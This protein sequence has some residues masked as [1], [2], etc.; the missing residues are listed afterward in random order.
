M[1]HELR[2]WPAL[3]SMIIG[4]FML[5]VDGTIVSIATPRIQEEL[6]ADI[7]Q[8]LWV[9][10]AYLLAYAVPLLVTG[11]LGDRL[12][13]KR[14]YLAGLA[15]FTLSSLWC[16]LSGSIEMLI[17]ARVVQGLGAAL[18][19]PQTMSVITRMFPPERRGPAMS[20]WGATA[21]VANL[22]GPILGGSLVDGL[23]WEWIFFVNVPVG[24][25]G[26]VL[27]VRLVPRF[28]PQ[29]HRFDLPGVLLSAL[30]MFLV[31]FGIQEGSTYDWGTISG[32]V[33]VPLLI[34][35]GVVVLAVFVLW[36]ARQRSGEPLVPLG[37]FRDRN[38]AVANL[39]IAGVGAAIVTFALPVVLWAQNVRG[40]SPTQSALLLAPMA[41]LGGALAPVVG[42]N[43]HHWNTRLLAVAGL[44][45]FGIGIALMG[46]VLMSDGD[47]YWLLLP[48]V[49]MGL[50]NAGMWAPLSISATYGLS[51]SQ[52][53]AGSGVYNAM[54]QLGAV[55]GSAAIAAM[56]SSRISAQFTDAGIGGGA[57]GSGGAAGGA[58]GE[59]G[60]ASGGAL[61]EMLHAPYTHAM[62]QSLLLPAAIIGVSVIAALFLRNANAPRPTVGVP[63]GEEPSDAR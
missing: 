36:Q 12:G 39:A 61:P 40:F 53:G 26:F 60:G 2:P 48:G 29:S 35:A 57:S 33:S 6:G 28:E 30:G 24:I 52:A 15:V 25:V 58:G 49:V 16:G 54:R 42:K 8:V 3:W 46:V 18:M 21:G 43:L 59:T 37:L 13:P 32:V 11:R 31:V 17:V 9:T 44:A 10:S 63:I 14:V 19:T 62:G 4:F 22:V 1:S 51:R 50:G 7:T 56:M 27:A 20:L 5:L 45:L 41:V 47:W 55:V 23:G 38:F 34:G